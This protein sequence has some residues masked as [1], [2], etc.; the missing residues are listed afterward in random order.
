MKDHLKNKLDQLTKRGIVTPVQE[1]TA[2]ISNIVTTVK[3]GKTQVCIDPQHLKKAIQR[4]KYQMPTLEGILLTLAKV[5]LFTALDAKD[6]C[7]T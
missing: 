1:P 4:P 3:P 2:W 6:G 7:E 5:K